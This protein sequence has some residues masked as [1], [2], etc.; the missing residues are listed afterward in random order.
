MLSTG[1]LNSFQNH[2]MAPFLSIWRSEATE[3]WLNS[4]RE[5]P[6]AKR[7]QLLSPETWNKQPSKYT[8]MVKTRCQIEKCCCAWFLEPW[9]KILP[10]QAEVGLHFYHVVNLFQF[11]IS[12]LITK[13]ILGSLAVVG[14]APNYCPLLPS[15]Q[16][17]GKEPRLLHSNQFS[18]GCKSVEPARE[19]TKLYPLM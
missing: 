9:D 16:Y 4:Q 5:Y 8:R 11:T 3:Y 2:H 12:F 15:Y 10:V 1:R 7:G 18:A 13:A 14:R 19:E 17:P 6:F